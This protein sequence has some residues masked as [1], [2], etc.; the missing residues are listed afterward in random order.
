MYVTP[1][2][3]HLPVR[4]VQANHLYQARWSR[5]APLSL[6]SNGF[7]L[8]ASWARVLR[9]GSDAIGNDA[10]SQFNHRRGAHCAYGWLLPFWRK[11]N[12][13]P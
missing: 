5:S 4:T 13:L 11:R 2:R 12:V 6:S 8:S 7:T 9:V 1:E 10:A 3:P